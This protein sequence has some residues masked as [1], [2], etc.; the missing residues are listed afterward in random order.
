MLYCASRQSPWCSIKETNFDKRSPAHNQQTLLKQSTHAMI[1][2]SHQLM[3]K[4]IDSCVDLGAKQSQLYEAIKR[5]HTLVFNK[6]EKVKTLEN[7]TETV[8]FES[9]VGNDDTVKIYRNSENEAIFLIDARLD[10]A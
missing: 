10:A 3:L 4:S 1:Y 5:E 2:A 8:V 9:G 6:S 7:S